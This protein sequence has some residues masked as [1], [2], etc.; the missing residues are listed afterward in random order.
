MAGQAGLGKVMWGMVR[1]G[2]A[3]VARHSRAG[4]GKL[5]QGQVCRGTAR[6]VSAG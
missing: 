6:P 2:L 1:Y 3:G 4:R 5:W